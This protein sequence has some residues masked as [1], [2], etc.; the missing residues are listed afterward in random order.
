MGLD[1]ALGGLVLISALRGWLRGFLLQAIRILGLVSSVYVAVPVRD[2]VKPYAVD[3]LPTMRPELVDRILWWSSAVV[4]YFV[5]VGVAS[6]VL[7]VSRRQAY[8]PPEPNRNDQFAGLGLGVLKGL[9]VA[10]F[11]VAGLE[12]YGQPHLRQ[13]AW[14]DEQARTSMAWDWNQRYHPAARVWG[15][16]PVQRFVA[17]V[18]KMGLRGPADNGDAS[19]AVQTASRTPKMALPSSPSPSPEADWD[20]VETVESL[21]KALEA[22]DTGN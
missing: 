10:S 5:I 9:L 19:E 1:L 17:H 16:P 7:A 14:A 11:L 12:R 22:I 13:V 8:G 4:S 21:R 18:Q 15:A 20:A 2:Q 6:L 3:Y